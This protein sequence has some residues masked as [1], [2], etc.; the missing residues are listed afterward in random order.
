[1]EQ[2]KFSLEVFDGPLELLLHLI[3]KN[4]VSIYDIP[5]SLILEQYMEY[6][7]DLKKMDLEVSSAFIEMAAQLMLIKSRML[8]PKAETEEEDP[9]MSLAEA[10]AEYKRYKAVIGALRKDQE[11]AGITYVRRTEQLEFDKKH[12]LSY[13]SSALTEAYRNVLRKSARA[14]P[15]PLKSFAGIV[16]HPVASVPARIIGVLRT[17]KRQITCSFR[18]LFK[19]AKTRSEIVATFLAVLELSKS[20][21]VEMENRNDDLYLTFKK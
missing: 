5:I 15:P 18:S 21:H 11:N 10:L 2:L 19:T 16:G 14:L 20:K 7:E 13:E 9:R 6:I 17:L 3:S 8:L 1:M 12:R 4:K